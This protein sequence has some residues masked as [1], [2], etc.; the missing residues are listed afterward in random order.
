MSRSAAASQHSYPLVECK[1]LI[2]N[3]SK[4][5]S[6]YQFFLEEHTCRTISRLAWGSVK[7]AA[8][9]KVDTQGL[10][11]AI[12]PS[13]AVPNVI[14]WLTALPSWLSPWKRVEKARHDKEKEFFARAR[15]NVEASIAKGDAESSYMK[16]FL[17]G[18][19]KVENGWRDDEGDY[20]VGMLAI[21]GA[22]T[23]ASPLMSY[24]LAMCHYPEWQV[25][26]QE[27]IEQV[28][29]GRCPTW[30]DKKD[31]PVLRAVMKEVLRWRPPVPTGEFNINI[32]L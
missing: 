6:R 15:R 11:E 14:S 24:I 32:G 9:L 20:C 19:G 13:G 31:L 10:L 23:I 5:P 30:E 7:Y 28:L 2:Y 4:D 22:L 26:L 17:E 27:E 25:R 29:G 3:L 18:K 1:R 21:A 16:M 12:S 8:E